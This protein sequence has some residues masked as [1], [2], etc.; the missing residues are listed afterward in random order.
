M[1]QTKTFCDIC[2]KEIV[3][4]W[5]YKLLLEFNRYGF[6]SSEVDQKHEDLCHTCAEKISKFVDS[7]KRE[8]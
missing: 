4:D 5:P 6:S 2:K 7:L 3:N 8:N 1:K